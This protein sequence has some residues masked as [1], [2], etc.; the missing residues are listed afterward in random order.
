MRTTA[1]LSLVAF[2]LLLAFAHAEVHHLP[3]LYELKADHLHE[4]IQLDSS[5][6]R[7]S[8]KLR[9]PTAD[10][11]SIEQRS[12]QILVASNRQ[13]LAEDKADLWDSGVV[14]SPQSILVPYGGR[15]L[16]SRQTCYWKVRITDN[17]GRLSG[18]S[19]VATWQMALL[20]AKDWSGSHW[21]GLKDDTRDSG[22]S[23]RKHRTLNETL[24]SHPSPLLRKN[25]VL[26]KEVREARAYVSGVG[27]CEFYVNGLKIGDSVL[28][29]GQTN[30]EK[31]TLYVVHDVTTALRAG[32]NALGLW[33]GNGFYGQ[34]LAF[35]KT[36]GYGAPRAR[37]KIFVEYTD[38]SAE[39]FATDAS[40]KASVSP[41][42]FDNIYWGESYDARREMPGWA[43]PQF[44]DSNWQDA[45]VVAPPCP[46]ERLRPQQL[47]PIKEVE[48]LQP[49]SIRQVDSETW[50]C[51][52]GKNISGWV[53][54]RMEQNAGDVIE[55][56]PSEVLNKQTGRADQATQGGSATG[57]PYRLLYVCHGKG[58]ESW[59]P[60]FSYSGF[61]YVEIRG[62]ST[63]PVEGSIEAVFV[64]SA[65]R[66]TGAFACSHDL[67]NKQYAVSLL[68]LES[69]W[70]ALPEDCPHREKCGWLG[71]AHATADL[72]LYNYDMAR[73][74]AKFLRDIE[75]SLRV[76]QR[77]RKVLRNSAGVP[78]MV[79]PGKRANRV[80]NIDW[81]V[82]Y[83]I[84]PWQMYLH[85]GDVEAFRP[86][87]DHVKDFITYYRT[88]KNTEGVIENG[89]GD[90][91]P[92]GW[93]RRLAPERMECPPFVSGTAFYYQALLIAG[94][95]A[96]VLGDSDYSRR[97]GTEAEEIK[98]AFKSAYLKPLEGSQ[99]E[100]FGSQT[101]TVMALKL[102]MVD[103][104]ELDG[105]I[106]GLLYDIHKL[107]DGHHSCGI[108][109]LR[110]LYTVLADHGQADLAFEM[111]TD[112]TFPS[113]GYVLGCGLSTWP[114][115]RFEWQ[116]ERFRN[117]FNHPMNGGFAAFMH[118]SL[119]G[120]RPDPSAAGYKHFRLKPQLTD[121]LEWVKSSVDSPY[122]E[123]RSEWKHEADSFSWEIEIPVNTTA[124]ILIPDS[125]EKQL[126]EG[127]QPFDA[128][129]TQVR[130][131]Q[132][133]WL[134]CEFGSGI[135]QFSFQ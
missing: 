78:T 38:G 67:L 86:H 61:Q 108:H 23:S 43:Q 119:G 63:A 117:S 17:R 105:L 98:T 123:I 53:Q 2:L 31:H 94:Q 72:C 87:Y 124:T 115:R 35:K 73:F 104:E 59:A 84:L 96:E 122:G 12:Y 6:P 10:A 30:Y 131:S 37:V 97:C 57:N 114:E 110:H 41:V 13:L 15:D 7:L 8:W 42:D 66:K 133:T 62:L 25:V 68:S 47:P 128:K 27:Y 48:R 4:P 134:Q 22:R 118:E 69:N 102:G 74:Y 116:K 24:T 93:D 75:D 121:H 77:V 1:P 71:D 36:F 14:S 65:V 49:V 91:C 21:I 3:E 99:L 85:T 29:P 44:D 64:R 34:N 5:T 129:L 80:A 135:Y 40:W 32:D 132:R 11:R 107:H 51:D 54:I 92:P 33:L 83:L 58:E 19:D 39:S 112:T 16:V 52:F 20:D 50:L 70:H 79:A 103:E 95:M 126:M 90:W 26:E 28:D 125:P 109:G 101:A 55:I 60:R 81:G 88:F 76:D 45:L 82:A 100:H 56:V 127:G 113:P 18:W 106:A 111:L 89:L 120:I 46:D 130:E 9:P